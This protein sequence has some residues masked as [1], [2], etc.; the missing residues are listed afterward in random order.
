MLIN[1]A[2]HWWGVSP[3][4]DGMGSEPCDSKN[5]AWLHFCLGGENWHNNHH[6]APSSASTWVKWYQVDGSYLAIRTLAALGLAHD[7]KVELPVARPGYGEKEWDESG[8][9]LKLIASTVLVVG[10]LAALV[11]HQLSLDWSAPEVGVPQS[12]VPA[13]KHSE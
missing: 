12:V 7:V 8:E 2:T 1:S 5:V 9:V 13:A 10:A 11:R 3:N 4:R 6:G